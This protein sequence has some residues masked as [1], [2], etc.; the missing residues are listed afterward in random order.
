MSIGS[1]GKTEGQLGAPNG[2]AVDRAG[3]IY[4]ADAGKHHVQKLAPDGK[5][6]AE[7]KG[8]ER[9]FYG[10]RRVAVGPDGSVYVVDQGHC[11][12][13]KFSPDG[14]ALT[15][16]ESRA[17]ATDNLMIRLRSQLI[18]RPVKFMWLTQ[19][20]SVYKCSTQTG[21]F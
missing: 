2:I 8:P 20:T 13:A 1:S 19:L 6:V 5:F 18:P 17:K 14:L 7:W 3:N 15:S 10:P 21:S 16:W 4:V 11:R 9:G 12:I